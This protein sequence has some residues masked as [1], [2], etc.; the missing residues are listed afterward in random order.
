MK[1][2]KQRICNK[3]KNKNQSGTKGVTFLLAMIKYTTS[4]EREEGFVF[5]RSS[6]GIESMVRKAWWQEPS[7]GKWREMCAGLGL[8]AYML[9][10]SQVYSGL[11]LVCVYMFVCAQSCRYP[12]RL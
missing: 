6:T 3:T 11:L 10:F 8:H 5:T 2:V 1:G 12:Q 9:S 7:V 4:N